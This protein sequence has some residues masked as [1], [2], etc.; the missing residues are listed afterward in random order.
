MDSRAID[1]MGDCGDGKRQGNS[2]AN[3]T[4][5]SIWESDGSVRSD[6]NRE[7]LEDKEKAKRDKEHLCNSCSLTSIRQTD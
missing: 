4:T 3:L 1:R 5:S 6:S 2:R 7:K